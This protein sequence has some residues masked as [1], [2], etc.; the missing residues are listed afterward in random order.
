MRFAL[1][2]ALFTFLAS[3][4]GAAALV[5]E[6]TSAKACALGEAV[7]FGG[8]YGQVWIG[9]DADAYFPVLTGRPPVFTTGDDAN[10]SRACRSWCESEHLCFNW[11]FAAQRPNIG[12]TCYFFGEDAARLAPNSYFVGGSCNHTHKASEEDK[13]TVE[14]EARPPSPVVF[15]VAVGVG[16]VLLLCAAGAVLTRARRRMAKSKQARDLEEGCGDERQAEAQRSC[17]WMEA[18]SENATAD[19]LR[20]LVS[21]PALWGMTVD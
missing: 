15:D 14:S 8:D 10:F 16:L 4:G 11:C 2:A 12:G 5:A 13:A 19:D 7:R 17:S 18:L 21:Q 1:F 20:S 6:V 3:I 9:N